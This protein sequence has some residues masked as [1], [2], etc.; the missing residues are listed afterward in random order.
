MN[1]QGAGHCKGT[2]AGYMIFNVDDVGARFEGR[3]HDTGTMRIKQSD[4]CDE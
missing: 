3:P 2:D 1:V 4:S